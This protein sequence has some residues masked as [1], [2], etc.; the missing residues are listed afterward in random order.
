MKQK[1][2]ID[3]LHK[4]RFVNAFLTESAKTLFW[5]LHFYCRIEEF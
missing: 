4:A 3:I 5:L 1:D 2:K